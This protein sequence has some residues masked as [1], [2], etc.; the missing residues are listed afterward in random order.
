[1]FAVPHFLPGAKGKPLEAAVESDM[2]FVSGAESITVPSGGTEYTLKMSPQ[3]GGTYTG[4]ITFKAE[5]GEYLWYTM[6]VVVDSPL[7][8]KSIDLQAT[9]RQVVSMEISL[10]NPL[11]EPITFDASAAEEEEEVAAARVCLDARRA[12]TALPRLASRL[13]VLPRRCF[14]DARRGDTRASTRVEGPSRYS[15]SP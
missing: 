13:R 5:T 4:S 6:E 12:S 14:L 3:I 15:E 8:S 2:P 10:V 7:E 9:V 11:P 1:M